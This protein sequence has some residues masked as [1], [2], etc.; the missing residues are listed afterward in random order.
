M[1][2]ILTTHDNNDYYQ[3]LKAHLLDAFEAD[4]IEK[5]SA[6][7]ALELINILP[8]LDAIICSDG[9]IS[10][11]EINTIATHLMTIK[12]SIPL[13][14]LGECSTSYESATW[15]P[16]DCPPNSVVQAIKSTMGVKKEA[17]TTRV[18]FLP[19]DAQYLLRL[20]LT[21]IN[22][23][24]YLRV[25]RID[26][27]YQF[28]KR[29]FAKDQFAK[30]EIE[31]YVKSGVKDFYIEKSHYK[32][33]LDAISELSLKRIEQA[34]NLPSRNQINEAH[35]V[36]HLS[37]DRLHNI[38]IDEL[39]IELT[40]ENIKNMDELISHDSALLDFVKTL[41]QD[42]LSYSYAHVYLLCLLLNK[43]TDQY[44]WGSPLIKQ[45]FMLAAFF[46]DIAIKEQH[47]V[48]CNNK[49][50]YEQGNYTRAE[51][52][53]IL[54]HA[55][56]SSVIIDK[57]PKM[58]AG[59]SDIIREHHGAKNG[60]GFPETLSLTLTPMSII[61]MV[62]E[63]FVDRYLINMNQINRQKLEEIFFE[64]EEIFDKSSYASALK[65]LKS[66]TIKK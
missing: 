34:K 5:K 66:F 31:K 26:D 6:K 63:T 3:L 35:N 42:K 24:L 33:F 21:S 4:I 1:I 32:N 43:M 36:F 61:F 59:V 23:D 18:D 27:D 25:K 41:N 64:L 15:L 20:N 52:E 17:T 19:I 12:S 2:Q 60:I 37:V 7:E 49:K 39:T 50:Q 45:R 51:K 10:A 9:Q 28:I 40:Q 57:F 62:T 22:A 56:N 38:G 47:L 46:H 11:L 16:K 8:L 54:N 30:E 58:M 44:D 14:I 13:I 55:L 53:I 29:Y 65:A 48:L